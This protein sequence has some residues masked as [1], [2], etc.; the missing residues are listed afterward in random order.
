MGFYDFV[1]SEISARPQ[2][3][4]FAN[5]LAIFN[6]SSTRFVFLPASLLSGNRPRSM[7]PGAR[8]FIEEAKVSNQEFTC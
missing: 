8:K 2:V 5:A 3:E 6:Q 1:N 7:R 4:N